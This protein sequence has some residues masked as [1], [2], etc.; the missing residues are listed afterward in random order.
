[1]SK[2]YNTV[3]NVITFKQILTL[4]PFS[5]VIILYAKKACSDDI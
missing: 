4:F 3:W 5:V 2:W 1:M